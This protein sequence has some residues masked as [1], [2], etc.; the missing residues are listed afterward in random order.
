MSYYNQKYKKLNINLE[1]FE[2]LNEGWNAQVCQ[3]GKIAFK[4]YFPEIRH[5]N[6]MDLKVFNILRSINHQHFIKL[7]D[8]Y[9]MIRE[10]DLIKYKEKEKDFRIDAYTSKLYQKSDI[11]PLYEPTDY[12]LDNFRE[13]EKLFEVF[14]RNKIHT[15]DVKY[16]NSIVTDKGIVIL[17]PDLYREN[18]TFDEQKLHRLNKRKL[19]SFFETMLYDLCE[20]NTNYE[21]KL[22][23][24][25]DPLEITNKTSIPIEIEKVLGKVKRPI[26]YIKK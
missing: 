1:G 5:F 6:R 20:G 26:D 21:A 15:E 2:Y 3:N 18:T 25:I 24:Q 10:E 23:N 4:E 13:L 22:H 14:S 19:L 7:Y 16:K 8:A 11:N 12:L 17:D 9:C